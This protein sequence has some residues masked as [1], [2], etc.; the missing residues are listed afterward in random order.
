M[1]KRNGQMLY[2]IFL[3]TLL[4]ACGGGGSSSGVD[5]GTAEHETY[6]TNV[7][8]VWT[9]TAETFGEWD[10][11][12]VAVTVHQAVSD[13]ESS[14]PYLTGTITFNGGSPGNLK[15]SKVGN[16]WHVSGEEEGVIG[17]IDQTLLSATKSSGTISYTA[18]G[19]TTTA[20][21]NLTKI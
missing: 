12:V 2:L 4:S 21:L 7:S 5:T 19:I 20:G 17:S 10:E 9:G 18:E 6:S 14:K 15:G 16:S 8:G 3:S 1:R 11:V 13:L